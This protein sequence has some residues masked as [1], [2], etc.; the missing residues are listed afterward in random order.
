MRAAVGMTR[1]L[2]EMEEAIAR[3]R[4]VLDEWLYLTYAEMENEKYHPEIDASYENWVDINSAVGSIFDDGL[5]RRLG[6]KSIDSM[7]FFFISRNEEVGGIIA[8]LTGPGV[9]RFSHCGDLAYDDFLF[10]AEKALE[11]DEDFCDYQLAISF[12]KCNSL[13]ERC[14]D[15][16]N[17]FFP[18]EPFV[19]ATDG[20][21]LACALS[22]SVGK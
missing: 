18:Q 13:D 22:T 3:E 16:L 10:L 17:G 2:E 14:V 11:R 15:L 20:A 1:S 4:R 9:E 12:K 19:H 5:V 6:Q 7:L 21:S 8:W